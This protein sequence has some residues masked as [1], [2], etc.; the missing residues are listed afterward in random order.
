MHPTRLAKASSFG[1]VDSRR[2]SRVSR[3]D[4]MSEEDRLM[5]GVGELNTEV[6]MTVRVF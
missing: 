2:R 6:I 5:K 1:F 4:M 3:L